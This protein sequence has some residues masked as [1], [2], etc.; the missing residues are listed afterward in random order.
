MTYRIG[1]CLRHLLQLKFL[2]VDLQFDKVFFIPLWVAGVVLTCTQS[3]K[4][5][6]VVSPSANM[7]M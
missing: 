4:I 1:W 5:V 3:W 2:I 6:F 7:Y